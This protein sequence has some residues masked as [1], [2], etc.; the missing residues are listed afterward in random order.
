KKL[1]SEL[2]I[3]VQERTEEL[4]NAKEDAELSNSAKSEFLANISHELRNPMHQILSYSKYGIDK[5]D[6]ADK[7]KL[8]HYYTQINKS[9]KKLMILLDDLLDLS[10]MEAKKMTYEMR[11][12]DLLQLTN[13]IMR[14]FY[15]SAEE[16][17]ISL[18]LTPFDGLTRL[19]F[20][21]YRIGQVLRNLL[22]N[23]IKFSPEG[24]T[25]TISFKQT[26]LEFGIEKSQGLRVSISDQGFGIP[27]N[28]ARMIFDKFTQ[29]SK[30]KTG[31]GG[32]GLGLAISHEII[33]AHHGKIWAKNNPEGGATFS[34]A[35]PFEQP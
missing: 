26:I 20:D 12:N 16:K 10:K 9:G 14:E 28:E 5:I 30:T 1:Y 31:A 2:E 29:S 17:S 25:I 34:F 4:Q 7:N 23:A 18:K 24:K 32:T 3:K 6:R 22:S 35:L 13:E 11:E 15:P 21:D 33:F 8:L 27:E 19:I